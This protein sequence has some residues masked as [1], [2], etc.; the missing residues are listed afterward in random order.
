MVVGLVSGTAKG[1]PA[2]EI[3]PGGEAVAKAYGRRFAPLLASLGL[4]GKAGEVAAVP[5]AGSITSPL[6]VLVGLGARPDPGA[7]R[8]AAGTAARAVTNA[9][10]VALALPA[11]SP[12]LVR[13]VV[14]GFRLGGYAFTTYKSSAGADGTP[15][16]AEVAVLSPIARRNEVVAAFEEGQLVADA[17][18][19]ARD[20]VNT[21]ANDLTPPAFAD[22]VAA[23]AKELGRR[24]GPNVDVTVLDE[25]ELSRR[26]FGGLLGVGGGS[27]AP[28]RLVELSYRPRRPKAHLA[29]VGKGITFDS[30]GL[31]IKPAQSMTT[32]KC[33]MAGAAAVVQA[34]FA[35]ARL[36][37]PVRISAYAAMAEN[38]ISGSAV[39]P[40]DVLTMY[41]GT[42]VEVLNTDAE[43]RLVLADAL[44]RAAEQEPD[45]IVDV[46]TLTGH[47][48]VALGDKLGGVMGDEDV[49]PRVLAAAESAGEDLWPMPIPEVME[50]R[51]RSSKVADLAQHDW[52]RWGG[53]LFA[54]AF[55][56]KFTGGRPWAHLDIA[57]PAFNSGG[58]AGHVTAGGTGF[59]VPTLVELARALAVDS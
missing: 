36:G 35:I 59:A 29:L 56:Q 8:R 26:G 41:G 39:R 47:M 3:A 23:A 37:L 5:T 45:V 51:I 17:V 46:A 33:D 28:P 40:G 19:G 54:A 15:A 57:G 34:T 31:T 43:G 13:A 2:P 10:S 55:L 20:W 12:A 18:A 52:V 14:E 42:T 16:V 49:V 9:A 25:Q 21:P 24:R 1:D 50:E 27:A 53:G 22:A 6:L 11:D 48:V 32:M 38:M 7:C 30:G 58:A 44:V 4:T